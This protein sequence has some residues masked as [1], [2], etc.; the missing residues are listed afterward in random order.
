MPANGATTRAFQSGLIIFALT[1]LI[2]LVNATKI[3]GELDHDTLLTHVHSGTLG[4]ITMGV[5][6][7]AI[8]V[9]AGAGPNLSSY[10][11]LS[12]LVTAAYVM[13]FWSGN[14]I[15]RA[16]FGVAELA[17][18]LYWWWWVVSRAMAE[19]YSRL[20]VPKLSLALGLTTLVIGSTLGV[21]LQI[22][23]ATNNLTQQSAVLI[24]THASAQVGGYLVLV[25]A[26]VIEFLLA[27]G[28]PRTRAG[29]VQSWLLFAGGLTLAVGFLL[30]VLPL[31]GVSNLLQAIGIGIVVFRLGRRVVSARWMSAG[32]ERHAAI[33]IPFL[34]LGLVLIIDLVRLSVSGAEIP[35]G[36]LNGLNHTMFVGLMTNTLFGAILAYSADRPRVWPWADQVI[37]WGLNDGAASFIAVLLFVGSSAG[38]GAFAHPV[39]F[40]A[41]IMG[42]SA[43]LGIATFLMRLRE[44]S[45]A[46][47]PAMA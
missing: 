35:P 24:P 19:G 32:A 13:A 16:V 29:E 23:Y 26:G 20:S 46:P 25:A 8:W 9:F 45:G 2:G 4:W 6:G 3:A 43:L 11:L 27:P 47:A 31:L 22:L 10:V 1:A 21:I 39:A 44:P 14:F 18:I 30:G 5:I 42:L 33:A 40:T 37:F 38:Q 34:V 28:L 7:I 15:L 41:P 12:A 17:V 36:L